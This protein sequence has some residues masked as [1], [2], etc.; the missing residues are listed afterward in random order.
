MQ[1]GKLLRFPLFLSSYSP[2]WLI[3]LTSFLIQKFELLQKDNLDKSLLQLLHILFFTAENLILL[4]ISIVLIAGPII[5]LKFYINNRIKENPREFKIKTKINMTNEYILYVLTYIFPFIS[6]D[7]LDLSNL[8]SLV[9]VI[10]TLG[11]L[12]IGANLYYVNPTL[13]I[14]GYK[15]YR[16]TDDY[17]NE[18]ILLTKKSAIR[19]NK[20]IMINELSENIYIQHD[21]HDKKE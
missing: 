21:N 7:I 11:I 2:L 4:I 8:F 12:Y 17:D 16:I 13:S 6:E 20:S 1:T 18:L 19:E 14:F 9:I 15:L 10:I 3:F 5:A